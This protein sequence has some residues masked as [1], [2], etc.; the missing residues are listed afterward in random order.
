MKKSLILLVISAMLVCFS[1]VCTAQFEKD[2]VEI[3]FKVGDSNLYVNGEGVEVQT[4][5]VTPDGVTLVP[6]RVITEAFGAEVDWDGSEKRVTLSYGEKTLKLWIDNAFAE[7]DGK[8]IQLLSAPQLTNS[9]TMVPLRFISESFDASVSYD[10]DTRAINVFLDRGDV[11]TDGFKS[12][13]DGFLS[14]SM[15]QDYALEKGENG[16]YVFYRT[17]KHNYGDFGTV[18]GYEFS[19]PALENPKEVLEKD[20]NNQKQVVTANGYILSDITESE[21]N[22]TTVYSYSILYKKKNSTSLR[23]KKTLR[24]VGDYSY[25]TVS[26]YN[27]YANTMEKVRDE[28]GNIT[29]ISLDYADVTL[30]A[31]FA[32]QQLPEAKKLDIIASAKPTICVEIYKKQDGF[33]AKA[34]LEEHKAAWT[35]VINSRNMYSSHVKDFEVDGEILK[36]YT[37]TYMDESYTKYLLAERNEY[38]AFI[39]INSKDEEKLGKIL[40]S[41]AVSDLS[42]ITQDGKAEITVTAGEYSFVLPK[43]FDVVVSRDGRYVSAI[44]RESGLVMQYYPNVSVVPNES[45]DVGTV[46]DY[47][48]PFTGPQF[49]YTIDNKNTASDFAKGN[50]DTFTNDGWEASVA[51]SRYNRRKNKLINDYEDVIRAEKTAATN[52]CFYTKA[53][54]CYI[55]NGKTELVENNE[56]LKKIKKLIENNELDRKIYDQEV[57]CFIFTYTSMFDQGKIDSLYGSILSSLKKAE[58]NTQEKIEA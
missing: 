24:T 4:P 7:C 19:T 29:S 39:S 30:P 38:Y 12:F 48:N 21:H 3:A 51:R 2:I 1:L 8:Q 15:P 27:N 23:V 25:L 50:T 42:A 28:K 5:Y 37:L 43:S 17:S 31:E 35:S 13:D 22:N 46:G 58:E 16:K 9:V 52:V 49:Y 33:D 6:V 20:R 32:C 26:L 41:L 57:H 45:Y 14:I 40:S 44:D 34:F 18:H 10:D 36:G 53:V 54:Y 55:D 56:R 11:V 47:S